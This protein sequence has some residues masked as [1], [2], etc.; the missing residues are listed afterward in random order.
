LLVSSLAGKA[1][2]ELAVLVGNAKV[3]LNLSAVSRSIESSEPETTGILLLPE[4]AS[5][6]VV[7]LLQTGS[8]GSGLLVV[9]TLGRPASLANP[10]SSLRVD[11][12]DVLLD[13]PVRVLEGL[14]TNSILDG[15]ALPVGE[16]VGDSNIGGLGDNV[17]SAVDP[18]GPGIGVADL[19]VLVVLVDHASDVVDLL[20]K[21]LGGDVLA[22]EI[23]G[24]DADGGDPAGAV[25]L[26]GVEESLLVA[27]EVGIVG[28]PNTNKDLH[29]G[30]L[31]GGDSLDEGVAVI[32]RVKTN[33]V[34][35]L[36]PALDGLEILLPVGLPLAGTISPV[37]ANAETLVCAPRAS[38]DI[39]RATAR[40]LRVLKNFIVN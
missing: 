5:N 13:L 3:L 27:T 10:D 39:M 23:F 37:G 35:T 6:G 29:A 11:S 18:G 7:E 34:E 20:G 24:T 30:G 16:T 19:D 9:R 4:P 40:V 38:P 8:R 32:G 26:D 31:G 12:L 14:G 17:V 15:N 25:L 1:E 28:G 33:S 22:V 21:L 2:L 36:V